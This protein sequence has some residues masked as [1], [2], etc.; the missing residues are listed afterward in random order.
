MLV[1]D[2]DASDAETESREADARRAI[3][4]TLNRDPFD[5]W[6][7]ESL[8]RS[9]GL[10]SAQTEKVLREL[11]GRGLIRHLPGPDEEYTAAGSDD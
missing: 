11:V 3:V 2:D 10:P 5:V 1:H 7:R 6:T 9:L 4:R 8:A